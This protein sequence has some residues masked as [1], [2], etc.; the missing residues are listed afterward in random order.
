MPGFVHQSLT[1]APTAHFT[2]PN[3]P[4][5]ADVDFAGNNPK[6]LVRIGTGDSSTGK[7]C[8]I[9]F[10]SGVSWNQ[11][12]G[13][14]DNVQGG[15]V[16]ISADADTILWRTNGNGVMVS[17]NQATFSTVSSLPSDAAIA[18]DK[19][20]N[21]NFYGASGKTFYVSTNNGATFTASGT[22]GSSTSAFDIAVHPSVTGDVWVSTDK[23]LF[24]STDTGAT[25]TAISGITQAWGIALG[26]PKSTGGYPAVFVA[27]TYG[28]SVAYLRSD[29]QGVNWVKINEATHGFGSISA[30]C[31]TADARVYG[32]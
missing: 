15:K 27:A 21:S 6:N 28:G 7:Q 13:A 17:R 20:T 32:R 4:T 25:F 29:D 31:I 19:K 14:P 11:H 3:W 26:A 22:L 24:H 8:A 2:N 9:S 12:F 10:D 1:S 16:A 18:S 30:N 5:S 23:G